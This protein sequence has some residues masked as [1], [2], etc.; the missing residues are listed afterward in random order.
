MQIRW[1]CREQWPFKVRNRISCWMRDIIFRYSIKVGTWGCL[2]P[3]ILRKST[4]QSPKGVSK[5]ALSHPRGS[6]FTTA[7]ASLS[8]DVGL[9][10]K[11]P[12]AQDLSPVSS[13]NGTRFEAGCKTM[14]FGHRFGS[15]NGPPNDH[16]SWRWLSFGV[17][18]SHL[19]FEPILSS[20]LDDFGVDLRLILRSFLVVFRVR[21]RT[22][23][24][25]I[26][27]SGLQ[28]KRDYCDPRGSVLMY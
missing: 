18:C 23:Q 25:L 26:F 21:P 3:K 22:C 10:R 2:M 20:I 19:F 5:H 27:A 4:L 13:E 14:S 12:L 24:T 9:E 16:F 15:Q 17:L 8:F 6:Q 1:L 11:W 28:R 7:C